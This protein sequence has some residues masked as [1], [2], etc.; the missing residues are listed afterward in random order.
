MATALYG[1]LVYVNRGPVWVRSAD[2]PAIGARIV[3]NMV[4]GPTFAVRFSG[5][6]IV[7]TTALSPNKDVP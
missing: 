4:P 1:D 2:L 6:S 3:N 5:R 7:A